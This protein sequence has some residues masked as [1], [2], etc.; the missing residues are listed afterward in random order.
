MKDLA[1]ILREERL[2]QGMTL[3][4]VSKKIRVSV[5][6]LQ[7][8][9]EG[10]FERIGTVL[11]I[12]GF[13]RSYCSA[14]GMDPAPLL[15]RFE[16]QIQACDRQDEGI[17]RY[18]AWSRSFHQK[19]RAGLYIVIFG[20]LVIA[21]A[22]YCGRMIA[23]K[24]A[25]LADSPS[26]SKEVYPQQ[27]LPLDLPERNPSEFGKAAQPDAGKPPAFLPKAP[28]GKPDKTP[29]G[30]SAKPA[31]PVASRPVPVASTP[32]P[33]EVLPEEGAVAVFQPARKNRLTAVASRKA[34]IEVKS[35]GKPVQKA[36]LQQGEKREWEVE[37]DV[38]VIMGKSGAISLSWNGT[39][40][41]APA[42]S[43]KRVVR[44]HLPDPKLV[45]D[46]GR[47]PAR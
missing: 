39:P 45:P 4:A 27:E 15:E 29:Q 44:L 33:G 14:L 2:R 12:R 42:Q 25:R 10:E 6:M 32:R 34:W 30:V 3:E 47:N 7:H 5:E 13:I 35:D 37:K 38:Q 8:M 24:R 31:E 16:T 9:E 26:A 17:Q 46:Q 19:S 1:D 11:L 21:G 41:T 23:E 40:V 20:L 18:G 43:S 28:E 36:T 22:L